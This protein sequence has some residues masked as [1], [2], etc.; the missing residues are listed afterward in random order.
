MDMASRLKEGPS[1][2]PVE[3]P[4][5]GVCPNWGVWTLKLKEQ[6]GG[7]G[8]GKGCFPGG[9]ILKSPLSL[10][11]SLLSPLHPL[12][13]THSFK[14]KIETTAQHHRAVLWT[15]TQNCVSVGSDGAWNL[16]L[17]SIHFH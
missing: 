16:P 9:V 6:A 14:E 12:P 5:G 17:N 4:G 1:Q 3:A 2:V 8:A 13:S 7:R 10:V 15:D 11:V